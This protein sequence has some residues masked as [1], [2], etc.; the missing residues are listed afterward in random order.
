MVLVEFIHGRNRARSHMH[1]H[2]SKF[3]A[4][5]INAK[6]LLVV[7]RQVE[8][9]KVCALALPTKTA[10]QQSHGIESHQLET[11]YDLRRLLREERWA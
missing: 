11:S 2:W 1:N 6:N 8:A 4:K 5:S 3:V 10:K 9:L 7:Q